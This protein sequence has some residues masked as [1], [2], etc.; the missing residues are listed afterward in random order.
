MSRPRQQVI[1]ALK[2][3]HGR[4]LKEF[5]LD[6]ADLVKRNFIEKTFNIMKEKYEKTGNLDMLNA[7]CRTIIEIIEKD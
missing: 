3:G 6:E 5:S 1:D 4:L 2:E 7:G